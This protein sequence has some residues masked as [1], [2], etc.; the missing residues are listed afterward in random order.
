MAWVRQVQ[1]TQ[2]ARE[3]TMLGKRLVFPPSTHARRLATMET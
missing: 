1:F 2:M 3:A